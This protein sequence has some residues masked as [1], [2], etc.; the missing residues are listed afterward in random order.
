MKHL[1]QYFYPQIVPEKR[2]KIFWAKLQFFGRVKN[3]CA[4]WFFIRVKTLIFASGPVPAPF[5]VKRP[6]FGI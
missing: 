3:L 1:A 2:R 5:G 4:C 6:H